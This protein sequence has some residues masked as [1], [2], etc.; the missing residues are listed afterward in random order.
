MKACFA[1][2]CSA[3]HCFALLAC[4]DS[5]VCFCLL[6]LLCFALLCFALLA[7]LLCF[8]GLL[9]FALFCFELLAWFV[10]FACFCLLVLLCTT[11]HCLLACFPSFA[12]FCSLAVLCYASLVYWR[13]DLLEKLNRFSASQE[14]FGIYSY[15]KANDT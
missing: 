7:R 1:L 9:C 12:S 3:L 6:A 14:I 8:V 10:S 15:N 5:F 4:F 13:R 2:I 11:L